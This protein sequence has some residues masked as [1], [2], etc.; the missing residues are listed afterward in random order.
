MSGNDLTTQCLREV[1]E[2]FR[3]MRNQ[4]KRDF[5]LP[6]LRDL[7]CADCRNPE[8]QHA[9]LSVNPWEDR[10]ATQVSRLLE[11]PRFGDILDPRFQHLQGMD[12]RNL[13][14]ETIKVHLAEKR[15]DWSVPTQRE[16]DAA[17]GEVGS[18]GEAE[19][20]AV[21]AAVQNMPVLHTVIQ[22]PSKTQPGVSYDVTLDDGG[23]AIACTCS[24]GKYG[25]RCTHRIWAEQEY[26]RRQD[27]VAGEAPERASE[28]PS[29]APQTDEHEEP[30][31]V[32]GVRQEAPESRQGP[33]TGL[34]RNTTQPAQGV[35]LDGPPQDG[36]RKIARDP[37]AP[38][39]K[40][41]T[42]VSPTGVTV[43]IGKK[44]E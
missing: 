24:A 43:T 1:Q 22:I 13:L 23:R 4:V 8:C 27:A 10:M 30:L 11:N 6:D 7:F 38:P 12:F 44:D 16:V 41:K 2:K 33:L 29:E 28:G 14:R 37:W 25:R 21:E 20:P 40:S 36:L 39:S 34:A 42:S 18:S 9:L 17:M 5:Q 26:Q 19:D 32:L 35:M 3:S 31:P 15:G